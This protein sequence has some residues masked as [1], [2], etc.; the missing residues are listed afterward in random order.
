MSGDKGQLGSQAI[1]CCHYSVGEDRALVAVQHQISSVYPNPTTE[2]QPLRST[3][4]VSTV[5]YKR[6]VV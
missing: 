6:E 5:L 4:A 1:L 2:E 3:L